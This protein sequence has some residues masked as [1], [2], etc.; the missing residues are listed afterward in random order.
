MRKSGECSKEENGK[1]R[2]TFRCQINGEKVLL[3]R[4]SE[5]FLKF[6]ERGF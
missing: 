2:D 1:R 4:G 6:N 5:K 3:N